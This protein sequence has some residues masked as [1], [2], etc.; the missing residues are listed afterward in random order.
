MIIIIMIT[1][2]RPAR[3]ARATRRS[4]CAL[5]LGPALGPLLAVTRTAPQGPWLRGRLLLLGTQL[6]HYIIKDNG[7][8][9][10]AD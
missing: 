5:P 7:L 6:H 4:A 3:P 8:V 9:L 10:L 1:V 2:A